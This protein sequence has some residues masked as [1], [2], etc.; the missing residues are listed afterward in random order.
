MSNATPLA[1]ATLIELQADF[2]KEQQPEMKVTV[3]FNPE[4]LK[5]SFANQVATPAGS[6]DNSSPQ[7]QQYVGTGTTKLNLQLWFD[8]TAPLPK[9]ALP[10]NATQ[11]DDVR[12]LT[13]RIAY[14]MTP[15][16]EPK[17]SKKYIPPAVRFAWGSFQFDGIMDALEESLEFFSPEGRP[18]RASMTL[19]LVQQRITAYAFGNAANAPPLGAGILG[20]PV[21]TLPLTPTPAGTSLQA[22]A[23]RHGSGTP[24]Q[25]IAAANGIE[26]PRLLQPGQLINLN[27]TLKT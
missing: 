16:E 11:T 14:F 1:K 18:L 26:N 21:G 3:Q 24:W 10:D 19:S 15:R 12:K 25:A 4:T 23:D 6:G 27:P 22:L 13:Q 7:S 2:Q 8:A 5:V 20:N 17:G 9:G